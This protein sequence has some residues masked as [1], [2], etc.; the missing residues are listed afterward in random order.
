M[1]YLRGTSLFWFYFYWDSLYG[2]S[3]LDESSNMEGLQIFQTFHPRSVMPQSTALEDEEV[4]WGLWILQDCREG[5][6]RFCWVLECTIVFLG[7]QDSLYRGWYLTFQDLFLLELQFQVN[8]FSISWSED[9]RYHSS[10]I[11]EIFRAILNF[12]TIFSRRYLW[13]HV[14]LFF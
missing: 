1:T 3:Q 12:F 5:K 11:Y 13:G 4:K 6:P 8:F 10:T 9:S 7:I 14:F 2:N